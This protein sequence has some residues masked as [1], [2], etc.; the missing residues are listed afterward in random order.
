MFYS[1][2]DKYPNWIR[3]C[4]DEHLS[5]MTSSSETTPTPTYL[6]STGHTAT[7]TFYELFTTETLAS[8]STE[9]ITS[10]QQSTEINTA[11][12]PSAVIITQLSAA[13]HTAG[14]DCNSGTGFVI[15][16]GFRRLSKVSRFSMQFKYSSHFHQNFCQLKHLISVYPWGKE[17]LLFG[18]P[19]S[20]MMKQVFCDFS[21]FFDWNGF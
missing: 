1:G 13:N 18:V 21:L 20:S 6:I 12:Q 3:A 15:F 16:L 5:T 11:E 10:T 9:G 14:C 8:Q 19:D 17:A 2:C 4:N 7:E